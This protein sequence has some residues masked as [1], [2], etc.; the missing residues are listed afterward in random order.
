MRPVNSDEYNPFAGGAGPYVPTHEH[1]RVR[2]ELARAIE[3]RQS[4]SIFGGP[5]G[6]GKSRVLSEVVA[7]LRD[8]SRV[9]VQL[10]SDA[11][12]VATQYELAKIL[13]VPIDRRVLFDA[14]TRWSALHDAFR[15]SRLR[16][17]Q[18]VLVVDG[19]MTNESASAHAWLRQ[20]SRESP[21]ATVVL[22]ANE[23]PTDDADPWLPRIV[24]RRLTRA[25][26]IAYLRAKLRAATG[27]KPR[28]DDDACTRIHG[29]A[30]GLP[31]TIDRLADR[32]LAHAAIQGTKRVGADEVDAV[33]AVYDAA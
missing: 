4:L 17:E 25:D 6:S 21:R 5:P 19:P 15:L 2:V 28:F 20:I 12:A 10:N 13:G 8:P 16:R 3:S 30:E 22:V 14:A 7:D 9:I 1:E 31:R 26:G 24:L 33:A 11:P 23:T 29:L 27:A 18:L 32:V